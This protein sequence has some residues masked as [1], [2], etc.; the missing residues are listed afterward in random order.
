MRYWRSK[1]GIGSVSCIRQKVRKREHGRRSSALAHS[2]LHTAQTLS[3][4]SSIAQ[5]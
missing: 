5:L 1:E 3:L 2:S 4:M